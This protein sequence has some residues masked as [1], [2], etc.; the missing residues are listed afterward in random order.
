MAERV[1]AAA[2][3]V[4]GIC[5]LLGLAWLAG[6]GNTLGASP[7]HAAPANPK[8]EAEE[9]SVELSWDAVT[10][11]DNYVILWDDVQD[12][13][14]TYENKIKDVEGTSYTHTG[15]TNFR[16]YHY[17][18]VAE[19]KGGR[20]PESLAV[21]ATPGPVPGPVEWTVV[22]AQ[23]PGHTIYFAPATNATHY[24]VYFAGLESLLAGRRPNA[25]FEVA[26]GSPYVRKDVAVTA[27]LYYRV[28]AMNDTRIGTDG[29][30]AISPSSIISEHE[31]PIAGVAFG[32]VDDDD[33]LDLPTA[34][35]GSD[36]GSCGT[37]TARVLADV[38]LGDLIASPRVVSDVRVADFN[39]DGFDDMFSNTR[40]RAI[41]PGSFALLHLN[42][43]DGEF[44][45]SAQVSSLAIAGVGGTILAAD[46]DNDGDI[47]VFAPYDQTRGDGARNW[48]LINDGAGQF[49]DTAA[50][51]GVPTNPGGASY[52]PNGGQAVDFDE[53]GFV[54][55]LF[56]SRLLLNNG[57]GTFRDGS[58]AA[59]M[60]VREDVGLKLID[61]DLDGDLDLIHRT[62]SATRLY[63][64][65]NGV[66]DDGT[67]VGAELGSG[68]GA[69]LAVCDTNGDGFE[70]VW[71]PG[72]TRAGNAGTPRLL[73][74]VDGSLTTSAVQK[75]IPSDP[76]SLVA[77]VDRLA[78]GDQNNDGMMDVLTRW[79]EAYRLMRTP[80]TLTKRIR[81]RIEGA[82]GERNQ[83]GRVVRVVPEGQPNRIM[84]RVVESGSGLRSQNMYDLL[85]GAPWAGDYDVTVRFATG[86]VTATVKAGDAKIIFADGRVEDI[87]PEE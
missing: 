46:F 23:D 28:I 43:G 18:I 52:V 78:C 62:D 69:G 44:Q 82:G 37:Y 3:A 49:T 57:D 87:D 73:V 32:T 74:N 27:A 75:G 29:P 48:L 9:A 50:A 72:N 80:G 31:L 10:D 66:F 6:C 63:R 76:D 40:T 14:R 60:P 59:H 5:A 84:T 21:S 42:Q 35:G 61:V 24:R 26:D 34:L 83:Q 39:G 77:H 12:G 45:T 86:E 68:V 16:E 51:A 58:A 65:T 85:F 2:R 19:T 38:G 20:G 64:N 4:T 1:H 55:L 25:A 36:T 13:P 71:F 41:I 53:D 56:G 33:C 7:P 79:G 67:I 47:D 30:V 11:A 22:T 15:L 17:R 81:L 70:D 54:D 8:A